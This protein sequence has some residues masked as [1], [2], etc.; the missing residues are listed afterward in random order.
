MNVLSPI[1][2]VEGVSL[3]TGEGLVYNIEVEGAHNYFVGRF[4]VLAH[5]TC[6][7][8]VQRAINAA[9]IGLSGKGIAQLSGTVTEGGGVK[10]VS[11]DMLEATTAGLPLSELRSAAA[12]M[13]SNASGG[14]NSVLQV[15]GVFANEGL[16]RAASR[17][18]AANGGSLSE[19][20]GRFTMTFL[21]GGM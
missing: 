18:A 5:N 3:D 6:S 8:V 1:Y 19:A 10:V 12:N 21:L 14:G 9:D 7:G 16:A 13:L 11:V 17:A 4:A 2:I 15:E 20:Q